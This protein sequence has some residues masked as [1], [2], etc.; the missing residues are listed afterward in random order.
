MALVPGRWEGGAEASSLCAR[1]GLGRV[2]DSKVTFSVGEWAWFRV[3][4]K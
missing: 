1:I 2:R 4:S 3:G